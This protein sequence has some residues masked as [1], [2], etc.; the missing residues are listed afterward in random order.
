MR[1][2]ALVILFLVPNF[3]F[4]ACSGKGATVV[5]VNG[6]F[7]S[8]ADAQTDLGLLIEQYQKK[9]GDTVTKFI[10]G[11]NPSHIG[12]YGDLYKSIVQAYQS[13]ESVVGDTDL[14]TILLQIH[15]QVT[16]Q[17]V[18]LVGHSQGTYYT[19][20]MYKYLTS[21]GVSQNSIA[22]YNIATPASFVAGKGRHLTSST[23]KVINRVREALKHAPSVESFGAG[24]ALATV[25]QTQPK[26]PL[27]SNTSFVLNP[28][29]KADE[30]GGHSFSNVYL[31]N[32]PAT[33][34]STIGSDISGLSTVADFNGDCFVKPSDGISYKTGKSTLV[35]MDFIAAKA[36]PSLAFARDFIVDVGT[37][38]PANFAA[39]AGAFF[40]AITPTPRTTNLQGSHNIVSALYGSSVTEKNL[41]EFGLLEDQGGAVVLAVQEEPVPIPETKSDT[42]DGVVL[43]AETESPA[44][45]PSVPPPQALDIPPLYPVGGGGSPGFGGGGGGGSAS[46]EPA[47]EEAAATD[48]TTSDTVAT[49]TETAAATTTETVT[50]VATSTEATA[51]A[52]STT[53][54]EQL[55]ASTLGET[56]DAHIGNGN[57]VQKLGSGLSGIFGSV[58]YKI[59][60]INDASG[61]GV[62]LRS[63]F[64]GFYNSCNFRASSESPSIIISQSG[65]DAY[66]LAT[67]TGTYS[68]D[69]SL[70]YYLMWPTKDN[71]ALYGAAS[72]TNP[73]AN[74][75][76]QWFEGGTSFTDDANI[77]DAAFRIC[78]TAECVLP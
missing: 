71:M 27:P 20:D 29:E 16:T 73:Y 40:S 57:P 76:A 4:A 34:V 14:T 46:P 13:G 70:D 39:S 48:T 44:A 66:I 55:D 33:I 65:N 22:V 25:A 15:P 45:P 32:A 43:G 7:T 75:L 19:N 30:N 54:A 12:G 49:T 3:A 77:A 60:G 61:W 36:G 17:K 11:Y 68:F 67:T 58:A 18:V 63:C 78:S 37:K 24:A 42:Q 10:N 28:A 35:V 69:P 74:G 6:I 52:T 62:V 23:D 1:Y 56:N 2:L 26:D 38:V 72:T 47:Q 64:P 21:H 31:E 41:R 59:N 50:E 53:V 9:S 51:V 8:L 5:Y